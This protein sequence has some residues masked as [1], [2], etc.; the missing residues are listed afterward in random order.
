MKLL[1]NTGKVVRHSHSL[2][3]NAFGFVCWVLC[4]AEY[5]WPLLGGYVPISPVPFA[6]LAGLFAALAIPARVIVQKQLSG[7][8]DADK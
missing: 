8:P 5:A 6:L 1:P 2:H 3:L 7:A 4:G